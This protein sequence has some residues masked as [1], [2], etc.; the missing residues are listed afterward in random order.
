MRLVLPTLTLAFAVPLAAAPEAPTPTTPPEAKAK[1]TG[2]ATPKPAPVMAFKPATLE[3][4]PGETF[5]V[6]LFVPNPK[7]KEAPA[8]LSFT[9]GEGV[10]VLA[11]K[12]WKDKLPRYGV[13]LYPKLTASKEADGEIPV[14]FTVGGQK[15]TLNVKIV[16]PAIEVIP[17]YKKLTVKVTSPY[18]ARQFNGRVQVSNPDRFLQDITTREFKLAPGQSAELLFPLPGA[19]AAETETYDFTVLVE[20]YHGF[21]DKRTHPLKFPS[22]PEE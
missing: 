8:E 2:K 4:A 15:A 19:A 12:R 16:R 11:D 18:T 6:E 1:P 5:D 7:G 9:S 3:L 20:G 21:K 17:A 13:K 14:A 22:Q 10:T